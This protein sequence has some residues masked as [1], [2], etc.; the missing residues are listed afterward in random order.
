MTQQVYLTKEGKKELEKKL[1]YYKTVRRP[2][3]TKKIG[4]AR[5]FGDLS[6]NAEYDAAKEEQGIIEGEIAEMELKLKTCIIID[7]KKLSTSKIG[8]GNTVKLYDEEFDEDVVYKIV[9]STESD[10]KNGLISNESPVGKAILGKKVGDEVQV[11]TP[12][13]ILNF[14]VLKIS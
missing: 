11:E 9:G 6:E 5:E 1:E 3:V 8:L 10:P 14:K 2:E 7:D 13:G 12:N 4:V